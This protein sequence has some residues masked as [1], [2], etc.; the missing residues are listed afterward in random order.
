MPTLAN[1]RVR[2]LHLPRG[3][4]GASA[5]FLQQ[6]MLGHI[7]I[8]ALQTMSLPNMRLLRPIYQSNL[9]KE[10][11]YGTNKTKV[12]MAIDPSNMQLILYFLK[13]MDDM[14]YPENG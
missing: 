12:C 7:A 11:L 8:S 10:L 5:N 9:P 13:A 3:F 4:R 14:R 1:T 2:N 6:T